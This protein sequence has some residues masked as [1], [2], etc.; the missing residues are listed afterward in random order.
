[1]STEWEIKTS[2]IH[3]DRSDPPGE[4]MTARRAVVEAIRPTSD[5]D[6]EIEINKG[7]IFIL[8]EIR[9]KVGRFHP[10]PN[11]DP[12]FW[13]E[14]GDFRR[15]GTY[16]HSAYMGS[17]E[18]APYNDTDRSEKMWGKYSMKPDELSNRLYRIAAN[19]ARVKND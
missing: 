5:I 4:D 7:D 8:G 2:Y 3:Y 16:K 17:G 13:G 10:I 19:I 11:T 9:S 1:M 6:A 12:P 14:Y 15:I 18:F